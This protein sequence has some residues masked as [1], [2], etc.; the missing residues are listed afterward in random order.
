M[1]DTTDIAGLRQA[2]R[3]RMQHSRCAYLASAADIS[4]ET[5]YLF[6]ASGA[7]LSDGVMA[8]LRPF[9]RDGRLVKTTRRRAVE[10]PGAPWL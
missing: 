6:A 7:R 5:L 10:R 3:L 9:R 4:C 1:I 2:V 8:A